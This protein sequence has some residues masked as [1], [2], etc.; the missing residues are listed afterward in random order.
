[1]VRKLLLATIVSMICHAAALVQAVRDGGVHARALRMDATPPS[2][3]D[4]P[5][6][7]EP[8]AVV[9]LEGHAEPPPHLG[10]LP[11]GAAIAARTSQAARSGGS[12]S[13]TGNRGDR[14]RPGDAPGDGGP[15]GGTPTR[16]HWLTMRGPERPRLAPSEDFLEDFLA[17]SKPL[18]PPPNIPGERLANEIAE[19]RKQLRRAGPGSQHGDLAELVARNAELAAEEL[20]PSGRGTFR[21][22]KRTFT[23]KVDADGGVALEDRREQLDTQDRMMQHLGIDPYAHEKLALL[24]RTRDQRV[25]VGER[26]RSTRLERAAELMKNNIDRLWA[27]ATD[28]AA[29][30]AGLFELWDDCAETGNDEIVAGGAAAR[31]FVIGVIRARLRGRDA[32]TAEELARLNAG[33]RSKAVFAPYE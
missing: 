29:R 14:G 28:L 26:T 10:R 4:S 8:I 32:Y 11:T 31:T 25:A 9:L 23:A 20:K 7:V 1:M 22:V 16:S 6:L 3:T 18:Q 17:H 19:L 12:E 15:S 27:I 13:S 24:D 5:S 30:K 2:A 33:R 21:A